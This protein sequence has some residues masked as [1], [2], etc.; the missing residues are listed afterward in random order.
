MTAAYAEEKHAD[1]PQQENK[2]RRKR[3]GPPPP[4]AEFTYV[5]VGGGPA[6]YSAFMA[7]IHKLP[8]Y[9]NVLSTPKMI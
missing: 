3:E 1:E 2:S 8:Y 6:T 5:I 9:Q 4:V 7:L